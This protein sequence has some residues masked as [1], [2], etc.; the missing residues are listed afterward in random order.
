MIE[1]PR[2]TELM[3]LEIDGQLDANGAAELRALLEGDPRAQQTYAE[4][5]RVTRL[6]DTVP[7][8]EPPA[9]LQSQ[10][11][12][13]VRNSNVVSLASR[14]SSRRLL[15]LRLAIAA[16]AVILIAF[17]AAPSLFDGATVEDMRGTMRG[18]D[19][20][21]ALAA[22][23][24]P[25]TSDPRRTIVDVEL[26]RSEVSSLQVDFD[27][28]SLKLDAVEGSRS[29][30]RNVRAGRVVIVDAQRSR[31]RLVFER[32]DDAAAR[33][34]LSID[35]NPTSQNLAVDLPPLTN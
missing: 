2:T 30:L 3:N 6:L 1:N 16:A 11:M 23:V 17:L 34:D 31:I 22:S 25:S 18:I 19:S 12:T 20:D 14:R 21:R 29:A 27:P 13:A 7:A 33:V 15:P 4:L 35:G 9:G 26:R 10:I 28:R 32:L 24:A 8:V 5:R